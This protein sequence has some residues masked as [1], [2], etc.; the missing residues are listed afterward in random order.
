M[1]HYRAIQTVIGCKSIGLQIQSMELSLFLHARTL[2][3][4][5]ISGQSFYYK[6]L[7]LQRLHNVITRKKWKCDPTMLHRDSMENFKLDLQ[8]LNIKCCVLS[9]SGPSHILFLSLFPS[10]FTWLAP[11]YQSHLGLNVTSHRG[12]P[13]GHLTKEAPSFRTVFY[14]II[15]QIILINFYN[16]TSIY[17]LYV[18]SISHHELQDPPGEGYDQLFCSPRYSQYFQEYL[19]SNK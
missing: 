14:S 9:T 7:K 4:M 6:V 3:W 1:H 16:Y 11:F 10:V 12:L 8:F 19:V 18:Y 2:H 13:Q 17:C 5:K 15:T